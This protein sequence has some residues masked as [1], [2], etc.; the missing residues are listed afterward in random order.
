MDWCFVNVTAGTSRVV[1]RERLTSSLRTF[2]STTTR[3]SWRPSSRK[4]LREAAAPHKTPS[5]RT[6]RAL[7]RPLHTHPTPGQPRAPWTSGFTSL[8][9]HLRVSL[10]LPWEVFSRKLRLK[11]IDRGDRKKLHTLSQLLS[12]QLVNDQHTSN[13]Y[14]PVNDSKLSSIEL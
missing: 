6:P 2:G 3:W 13:I 5:T 4:G 7:Q 12:T 14:S 1:W 9:T 11:S 8:R 10:E